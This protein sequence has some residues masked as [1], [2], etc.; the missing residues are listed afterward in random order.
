[1]H[2][3]LPS[4]QY[5]KALAIAREHEMKAGYMPPQDE[6][7]ISL[8]ENLIFALENAIDARAKIKPLQEELRELVE[9]AENDTE[10]DAR[11][12]QIDLIEWQ[13][14]RAA[15]LAEERLRHFREIK[16]QIQVDA[17]LKKVEEDIVHFFKYYAWGFD[18]RPDSPLSVVPFE[19]FEFQERYV[20]W[21]DTLVF[22]KR[23]SGVVEKARDMGATETAL[24]WAIHNW[25]FRPGF[26]AI[27]LS[28]NEDLV[29]SKKNEN[30]LFEKVRFQMRLFPTWFLPKG[31]D[32]IRDMPYMNIENKA[33]NSALHGYA[34]TANVGRQ[35][36]A[37]VVLLD[38]YAAWQFGGFPQHTALSATSKSL[39]PLSSVQGKTNKFG[40]LCLDGKTL[41]FTM[42]WREHPWKDDRWYNSLPHGY[43]SPAMS[44]QQ[45]AQEIDRNFDA[46]QPGKVFTN[47]REEYCFITWKELVEYYKSHGYE[48]EFRTEQGLYRVPT[49][50][51]WGRTFDFGQTEGHKWGYMIAARP[52]EYMPLSDSMFVFCGQPMPQNGTTEQQA[53]AQ[54][55]HWEKTLGLRTDDGFVTQPQYSECSHE[56]D[57][58]RDTLLLVYGESWVAWDTDYVDGLSQ[59]REWFSLID[60]NK[61]NPIRPELMGRATIYFVAPDNEYAMFFNERE[62]KWFVTPSQTQWGYK[63]LREEF[64]EY[65]YP[66]EERFK[67]LPK[68][69]PKKIK[70]DII[71]NLRGHATHWGAI[72]KPLTPMQK[73]QKRLAAMLPPNMHLVDTPDGG[74]RAAMI[75]LRADIAPDITLQ[76]NEQR[77]RQEMRK[78]GEYVPNPFD[79][80]EPEYGDLGDGW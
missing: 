17:E 44:D 7:S 56:Q 46:S 25:R 5:A 40:D 57:S 41:K 60:Q 52:P 71:D 23:T 4:D 2:D 65:H 72:A 49:D 26:S 14:T 55:Q 15:D 38:E 6:V 24:R 50:F 39:I 58:L 16:T 37:T 12:Y 27:L 1:M 53:V 48:K 13:L 21:L 66:P 28:A 67:P 77:L 42:D 32:L 76:M 70:D 78:E 10:R 73:Y 74:K 45:I 3:A 61:P 29:D 79:D 69:R 36:R 68:Q 19:L 51:E 43:I 33:I 59:I 54:W 64:S 80:G 75:D 30:T 9:V 11:L 31:F 8:P 62:G 18:P 34:P 63:L 22:T 35:S 47:L 20:K